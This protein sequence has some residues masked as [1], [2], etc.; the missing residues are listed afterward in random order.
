[1]TPQEYEAHAEGGTL[2]LAF[3][4]M[5]NAGKSYRSKVLKREL[6][7]MWYHVDHE[8]EKALGIEDAKQMSEWLGYP[9]DKHYL[10]R[11]QE[12]LTLENKYTH[13]GA[14]GTK[15][16]NLT[17]DTTGSVV[18]LEDNTTKWIT[19]NCLII[20]IDVGEDAIEYM[21]NKF[22]EDPK[23]VIWN[24]YFKPKPS[25]QLIDT[26]NRCYPRLLHDRLLQYRAIAHLNIKKE[27]LH[28]RSGAE[29]LDVI[30]HHLS[31]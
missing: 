22:L 31:A 3:V 20:H 27:E 10:L 23:P 13:V 24:G 7:F 11:E 15:G 26:L 6:D 28:D 18:Y 21:I 17:F 5:S 19:E 14:L 1:L 4:G 29:T 8:I 16:K 25:E 12:Y 30:K 9:G 2:R